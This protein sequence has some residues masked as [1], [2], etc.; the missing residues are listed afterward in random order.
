MSRG[1]VDGANKGTRTIAHVRSA[2]NRS[3]SKGL[4]IGEPERLSMTWRSREQS[5]ATDQQSV[6][7]ELSGLMSPWKTG[8]GRRQR[9]HTSGQK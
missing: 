8:H 6:T 5:G 9:P 1:G 2:T 4:G 7:L 3:M